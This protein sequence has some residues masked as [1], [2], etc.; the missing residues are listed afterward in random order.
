MSNWRLHILGSSSTLTPPNEATASLA[1]SNGKRTILIDAGGNIPARL[2]D[3]GLDRDSVTD[4]VI[5]HSHPDHT[6]GLPFLSHSYYRN[7]RKI[8]CWSTAEAIPRLRESLEAYDLQ[9]PDK[10]LTVTFNKISTEDTTSLDLIESLTI[11][12][13]PNEHSRPGF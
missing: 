4:V 11:R 2:R 8:T 7:H 9:Q 1:L 13:L 3:A 12:T 6:Y 5:T 10:Y